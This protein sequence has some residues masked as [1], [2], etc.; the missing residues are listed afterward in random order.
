MPR[1]RNPHRKDPWKSY[2]CKICNKW[3]SGKQ[4]YITHKT[5]NCVTCLRKKRRQEI[6]IKNFLKKFCPGDS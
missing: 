6:I 5:L 2:K 1:V 4:F 3:Q